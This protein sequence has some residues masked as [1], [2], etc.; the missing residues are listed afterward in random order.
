MRRTVFS[1]VCFSL[2]EPGT[3]I[4]PHRGPTNARVRCHLGLEVPDGCHLMVDGQARRWE[5]GRCLLFDDS[6]LHR[7]EH[8]G[9]AGGPARAL[10]MVDM[11][12]PDLAPA[13]R[14]T[15]ER[16][17]RAPQLDE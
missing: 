11:W 8:A 12:H 2:L 17:L 4:E 16:V 6:Y 3:R 1:N 13:E 9:P 5:P 10:L 15:L 14:S 7:A